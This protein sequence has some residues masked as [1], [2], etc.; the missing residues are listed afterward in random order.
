MCLH[1]PMFE[2][3]LTLYCGAQKDNG[4][5]YMRPDSVLRVLKCSETYFI[6]HLDFIL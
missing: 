4:R 3:S 6:L 1:T 5:V 2:D